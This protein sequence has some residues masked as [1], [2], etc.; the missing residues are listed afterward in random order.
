MVCFRVCCSVSFWILNWSKV[1]WRSEMVSPK[2]DN[3]SNIRLRLS[4]EYTREYLHNHLTIYLYGLIILLHWH[5]D[6]NTEITHIYIFE[7]ESNINS[8]IWMCYHPVRNVPFTSVCSWWYS[9]KSTGFTANAILLHLPLLCKTLHNIRGLQSYDEYI[10]IQFSFE[11]S[12][13]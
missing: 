11:V 8:N 1:S 2:S 12:D 4:T 7:I 9:D 10:S 3:S 6:T 13:H 5:I